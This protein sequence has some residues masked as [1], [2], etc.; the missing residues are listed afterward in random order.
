MQRFFIS[1]L[2]LVLPIL[3]LASCTTTTPVYV[4]VEGNYDNWVYLDKDSVEGVIVNIEMVNNM[5]SANASLYRKIGDLDSFK[6]IDVR[7]RGNKNDTIDFYL[8]EKCSSVPV[9]A[10]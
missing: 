3:G 7:I 8:D 5:P 4:T 10:Q 9:Y 2:M 1:R 6:K